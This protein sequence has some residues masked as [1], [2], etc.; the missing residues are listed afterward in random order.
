M[1]QMARSSRK[2][3]DSGKSSRFRGYRSLG[4]D[5][6]RHVHR[7]RPR[8][9]QSPEARRAPGDWLNAV[10][11]RRRAQAA[12]VPNDIVLQQ[13][14][15][16]DGWQL[17]VCAG[18]DLRGCAVLSE[19]VALKCGLA[20]PHPPAHCAAVCLLTRWHSA[21]RQP[22]PKLHSVG[23]RRLL[24]AALELALDGCH[25]AACGSSMSARA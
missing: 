12:M 8:P 2:W 6:Q 3:P 25:A 24:D 9:G 16:A 18:G 21:T 22:D 23:G 11:K 4:T 17:A 5:W 13:R 20:S 7:Q 15:Q 14:W 1:Q 19:A 10:D